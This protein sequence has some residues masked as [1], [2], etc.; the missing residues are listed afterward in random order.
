[1]ANLALF[2]FGIPRIERDE[3]PIAVER[4][5]ALALLAYLAVTR[6]SHRRETLAALLWP[7]LDQARA[8]AALRRTLSAL[9]TALGGQWLEADRQSIGLTVSSANTPSLWVDVD[10]FHRLLAQCRQHGHPAD[11]VCPDCLLPL[12]EAVGLVRGD[13]L[14]GFSLRDSPA[15]DDWQYFQTETLR[16]E[17]AQALAGLVNGHSARHEFEPAIRYARHW[18]ALDP[19]LEP[20]HQHLMQ[21]FA[22]AGQRSAALRQY[23]ECVRLLERELGVAPQPATTQ[24]YQSIKANRLAPPADQPFPLPPPQRETLRPAPPVVTGQPQRGPA[25]LD[26]IVRGQLVGRERELAAATR[27]WQKAVAG[28][29]QILLVSGEPGIGKTRLVRELAGQ[30]EAAGGW[31]L[32][33]ACPA[34]GGPPYGP[35]AQIVRAVLDG[36]SAPAVPAFVLADLLTL[37]PQLRPRYPHIAPNVPL[38]PEF[39]QQ[40]VFDSFVFW[41]QALALQAPVLL[42]VEDVHWADSGTLALLQQ[43]TRH[44]RPVR[45][46]TVLTYRDAEAQLD[47]AR[48][49]QALLIELNRER[50]AEQM[51]LTRLSREQTGHLLANMLASPEAISPEF[52]DSL[53]AETEGNPF[54]TEEVCK[55]LIEQGQ[56]YFAGGY[57]RRPEMQAIAIPATVRAAILSRVGKLPAVAQ[58]ALRL[59]AV[60]GREFE[61]DPLNAASDDEETLITALEQ[62]EQAQLLSETRRAGRVLFSF[63]HALIPFT[64]R[65]SVS[66]LRLQRLHRRVALALEALRPDDLEALAYHLASAGEQDQAIAYARRAAQRAVGLYAFDVAATQLQAALDML[67]ARRSPGTRLALLEELADVHA[68]AGQRAQAIA[69]Y[70]DAL[71]QW[72]AISAVDRWTAVRLQHKLAETV[73]SFH[74][75]DDRQRYA[76]LAQA[77]LEHGLQ[78]IAGEPPRLEAARLLTT[79]ARQ[80]YWNAFDNEA[81]R[82]WEPAER[83]ARQAVALAEALDAPVELSAALDVLIMIYGGRGLFRESIPLSLQRLALSRDPRFA[84]RHERVSILWQTGNVLAVVGEYTQA[85]PYL[86]EAASLAGE[87][88]DVSQQAHALRVQ[89]ECWFALDR[90]D[91]MLAIEGKRKELENSYGV[92]LLGRLCSFC[93]LNA[94]VLGLRGELDL[95]RASREEVYA[96]MLSYYGGPPEVWPDAGHF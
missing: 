85:L 4:H 55:A 5:K 64:L 59:A 11:Q 62:A 17:L 89:A 6:A 22:W 92:D 84:D 30:S 76:A 7:E 16:R 8:R 49:L 35:I 9:N 12:A 56:L 18:L 60:F 63:A 67:A 21:L 71:G 94:N 41:C 29:G 46:L 87:I 90:W 20:P 53:Y 80:G 14:A 1:M 34:E 47:D 66:G 52:L 33:G 32:L 61:F 83:F 44:A 19:L 45:L 70:Q 54:F 26:R 75:H 73:F 42:L 43:L 31:L 82:D 2:L 88:R 27:L 93:G 24:L 36:P 13:F 95:A 77:S 72:A 28:A 15:F 50:A 37:A 57:W 40:R 79:L 91:E 48:A 81:G 38:E 96:F 51:T 86:I 74:A 23:A 69:V 78:L 10:N 68:L 39:E 25:L 3:R 58:E 65:Q